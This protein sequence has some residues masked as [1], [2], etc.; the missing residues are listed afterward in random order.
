MIN[1]K[2][3][4]GKSINLV[5]SRNAASAINNMLTKFMNFNINNISLKIIVL[6]KNITNHPFL[7]MLIFS[8]E[9]SECYI[10]LIN[11]Y[12]HSLFY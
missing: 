4:A 8:G 9:E 7:I 6:P 1:N 11:L 12:A 5:E 10:I 3:A 2:K